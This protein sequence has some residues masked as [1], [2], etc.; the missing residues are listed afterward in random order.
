MIIEK[1]SEFNHDREFTE[2][3]FSRLVE[4]KFA[5][6]SKAKRIIGRKKYNLLRKK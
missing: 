5:Y 3:Q 2:E 4:E 1:P 6:V